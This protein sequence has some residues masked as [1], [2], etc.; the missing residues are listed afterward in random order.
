M[1][2]FIRGDYP[3]EHLGP[4]FESTSRRQGMKPTMIIAIM[5]FIAV[6]IFAY[7]W[8]FPKP[9]AT[10][11][12]SIGNKVTYNVEIATSA[13]QLAHGLS[14]R[15]SLNPDAAMLFV[16]DDAAPRY[17]WMKDM[18]FALDALWIRD[19]KVV[20]LAP[21]LPDPAH[22]NGQVFSFSSPMPAD[23]VLE[24]NAGDIAKY[25]LAVGDPIAF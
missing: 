14:D 6:A 11:R 23:M 17:F 18:R 21:N 1:V 15:P 3:I 10:S 13:G 12:L 19:K 4:I 9:L 8:F 7:T 5:L 25:G 22:N 16:F 20:G 24:I 2:R